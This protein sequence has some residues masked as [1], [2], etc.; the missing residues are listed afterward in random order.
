MTPR[1]RIQAAINHR[2]HDKLAIDI[3]ATF[4]TGI[5][6]RAYH[7][8]R[9]TLELGGDP[10]RIDDPAQLLAEVEIPVLKALGSDVVGVRAYGGHFYGWHAWELSPG[11]EVLVAKNIEIQK[12]SDGGW[13]QYIDGKL[14]NIMPREGLYFDSAEYTPWYTYGP[15]LY[16]EAVLRNLED[17]L[18]YY[19]TETDYAVFY[20]SPFSI[21]NATNPDYSCALL[22]EKE[23]AQERI[24]VWM[25]SL[26]ENL[27]MVLDVLR[28]R[29][30]VISF[31]GDAGSQRKALC[32]P[33]V[34]R[35]MIVP[36]VR[37]VTDYVHKHSNIKCF[38][39]SCGSV[40]ELIE[41]FIEMG[42][43]ILNPV[44]LSAANMEP[45][46]LAREFGGRIVF[47][48]GGC[49]TQHALPHHTPEGVRQ[50]VRDRLGV[51]ARQ[52]GYV[53][54]QVHNIQPDVPVENILAMTNE[55]RRSDT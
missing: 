7:A 10:I 48:G 26:L 41:C 13:D 36:Q 40:Y 24:G 38:L 19:Q 51:F 1:E 3:G 50:E 54:S 33:E 21:S 43:D 44:Q 55:I 42:M 52:P 25:D 53:F 4:A 12:R 6:A 28:D 39:H 45:E 5:T 34:Y 49:D 27:K 32:P 35:E 18:S 20:N 2:A 15:K 16:T 46:R 29:A 30:D 22:I 31:S 23:E 47:W 17:R 37:R 11:L 9:Q 8:L 14:K